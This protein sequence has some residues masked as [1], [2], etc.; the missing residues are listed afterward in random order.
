MPPI[1]LSHYSFLFVLILP[2]RIYYHLLGLL[3]KP[4]SYAFNWSSYC[5]LDPFHSVPYITTKLA[6]AV[7]FFWSLF[8][9]GIIHFEILHATKRNFETL[10]KC[11]RTSLVVQWLRICLPVQ[12]TWIPSLVQED[13]T[14]CRATKPMCHNSRAHI[15]EHVLHKRSHC[16]E[17]RVYH[18]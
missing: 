10:I 14:L 8:G 1:S 7:T 13:S 15:P 17:K 4:P 16:S 18:N 3:I 9:Y 5:K 12:K 6:K 11:I 2:T